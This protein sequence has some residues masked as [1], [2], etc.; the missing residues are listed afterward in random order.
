MSLTPRSVQ[1]RDLSFQIQ[2]K[3][4]KTMLHDLLTWDNNHLSSVNVCL[5]PEKLYFSCFHLKMQVD[6]AI[7]CD[8][9][10]TATEGRRRERDGGGPSS[11]RVYPQRGHKSLLTC[12]LTRTSHKATVE[13]CSSVRCSRGAGDMQ[14]LALMSSVFQALL[15]LEINRQEKV[16][17]MHAS[18][19]ALRCSTV[20]DFSS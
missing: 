19:H 20:P 18:F 12:H 14:P 6:G 2:I 5:D 8:E 17:K 7:I 1:L 16:L 15:F 9:A 3:E 11:K 4:V 13:K 10:T